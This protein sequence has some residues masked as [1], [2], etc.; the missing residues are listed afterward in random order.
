MDSVCETGQVVVLLAN[1]ML[2]CKIIPVAWLDS[3]TYIIEEF[4]AVA[5][6]P[7]VCLDRQRVGAILDE[8]CGSGV[9]EIPGICSDTFREGLERGLVVFA[10]PVEPVTD[11]TR[12]GHNPA[13]WEA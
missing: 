10:L 6:C 13:G 1:L 12:Y 4:D 2:P 11:V 9:A 7:G 8:S 5:R 3:R